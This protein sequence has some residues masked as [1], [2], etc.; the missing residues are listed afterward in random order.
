M[1]SYRHSKGGA[2]RPQDTKGINMN[3]RM[4]K[5]EVL[6]TEIMQVPSVTHVELYDDATIIVFYKDDDDGALY[7]FMRGKED[8]GDVT[9]I[10]AYSICDA[11]YASY[12]VT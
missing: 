5:A 12:R 6:S 2:K 1:L 3:R 4:K 11:Y 10:D 9:L 7:W 8:A